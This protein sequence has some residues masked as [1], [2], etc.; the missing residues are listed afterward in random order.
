MRFANSPVCFQP[1][2]AIFEHTLSCLLRDLDVDCI[3]PP[4]GALSDFYTDAILAYLYLL[5]RV[6]SCA[7]SNAD[8]NCDD[9]Q[10]DEHHTHECISFD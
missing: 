7:T 8:H 5:R 9:S 2:G 4:F 3:P 1:T 6:S 10:R